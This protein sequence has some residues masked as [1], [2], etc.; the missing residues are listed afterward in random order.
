MLDRLKNILK[1]KTCFKFFDLGEEFWS[2]WLGSQLF[3]LGNDVLHL[4]KN[5]DFN[6]HLFAVGNDV[7]HLLKQTTFS[8]H[9]QS[10]LKTC[11]NL[12]K[13]NTEANPGIAEYLYLTIC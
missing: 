2:L 9:L 5:D 10:P 4:L 6:Y 3:T 8:L 7:L 12:E 11:L 1:I 13:G